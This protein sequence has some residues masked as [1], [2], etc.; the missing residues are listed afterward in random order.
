MS[1]KST[2]IE[3]L[4]QLAREDL[5]RNRLTSAEKTLAQAILLNNQVSDAFYLMGYV[6]SKKGKLKKAILAFERA[7]SMDPFHTEAAIALSSLY[8]DMGKYKE[9]ASVYFK[10]R[11]RLDRV[12]PG[13]DPRINQ[14]LAKKHHDLGLAYMRYER[15]REAYEEFEKSQQLEPGNVNYPVKMAV[16]LGKTGDRAAAADLL[17]KLL[18]HHPKCIEA[19][20]QLGILY[21]SLKKI[22][23]AYREWQGALTIDPDHKSAQMY[24]S[25]IESPVSNQGT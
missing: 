12:L 15:F 23:D 21:H 22:Q 11:K 1:S 4:L 17:Q 25:M 8:N 6:Y 24:L 2:N 9:G 13:H 14:D 10:A 7:L 3:E 20:I 16:C 19:K 5:A 18:Q